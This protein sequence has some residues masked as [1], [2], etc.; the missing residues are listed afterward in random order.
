MN[1]KEKCLK[2]LEEF[3]EV[4]INEY[5]LDY[6]IQDKEKEILAFCNLEKIE[7]DTLIYVLIRRVI[8]SMLEMC[9]QTGKTDNLQIEQGIKSLSEGD[10]SLSFD[11]SLDRGQLLHKFI[12][13]SKTY[14]DLYTWRRLRW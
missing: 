3:G 12:N 14:G 4:E 13:D 11:N 8:G 5:I 6:L 7:D 2:I 9:I 10:V 1:V